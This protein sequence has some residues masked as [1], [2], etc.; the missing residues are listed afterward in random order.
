MTHQTVLVYL[1]PPAK[2][3]HN[4]LFCPDITWNQGEIVC[5]NF[6]GNDL[7]HTVDKEVANETF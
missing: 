4:L 7:M 2:A 6:R 5:L 3:L 1:D